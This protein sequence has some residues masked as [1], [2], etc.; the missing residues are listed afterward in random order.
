MG[1]FD[2]LDEKAMSRFDVLHMIQRRAEAAALLYFTCC[3][4]FRAEGRELLRTCRTEAHWSTPKLLRTM[5]LP[6]NK[7]L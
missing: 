1:K 6:Y 3:H 2:R 4:T 7:A 5:N